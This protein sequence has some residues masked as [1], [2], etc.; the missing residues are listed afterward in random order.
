MPWAHHTSSLGH[1]TWTAVRLWMCPVEERTG[2]TK[3]HIIVAVCN[4]VN[5][6]N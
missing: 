3:L 1:V 6:P 5:V 4:F 2:M